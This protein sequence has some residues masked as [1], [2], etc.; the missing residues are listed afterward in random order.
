M[1]RSFVFKI[2]T[3][4]VL[5]LASLLWSISL[6]SAQ[7]PPEQAHII[8][9]MLDYVAV[10][11]PEFVQDGVVL[12]QA[13]YNEQQEFAQQARTM[14][15]QLPAHPDKASL[16]HLAEQLISGVQGKRPGPEVAA[17]AQQ[18]RWAI[19]RAYDVDV[20]PKRPPMLRTATS[21]Y[22]AHCAACHGPEGHGDGPS[23]ASLNP[24]PSNFHDRH[25]M[26]QRSVYGLYS[27]ITSGS[28]GHRH[29]R[30]PEAH[31]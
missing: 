20:A 28:P 18:L 12:N 4:S 15:D 6:A 21:L 27:T 7:A 1:I 26:E 10:D 17:L 14:L 23:A 13:E 8:L 29:V 3:S 11:Y 22:Q 30:F 19:I 25:R 9:Q 24:S 16:L 2:G 31:A 5:G